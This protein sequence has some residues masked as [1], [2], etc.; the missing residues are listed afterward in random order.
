[1]NEAGFSRRG[2]AEW[3]GNLA[4][5][6]SRCGGSGHSCTCLEVTSYAVEKKTEVARGG[7]GGSC[8]LAITQ[9]IFYVL[10]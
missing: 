10:A 9:G 1:M 7:G 4:R 5:E 2:C 6:R 3:V 8:C